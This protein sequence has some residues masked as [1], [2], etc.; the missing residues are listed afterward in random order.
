MKLPLKVFRRYSQQ[1]LLYFMKNKRNEIY[2]KYSRHIFGMFHMA[3]KKE[4]INY[5]EHALQGH[6]TDYKFGLFTYEFHL[7]II[8][9]ELITRAC[10]EVYS[11]LYK[12]G[13]ARMFNC[14]SVYH[15][16]LL[17]QVSICSNL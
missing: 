6:F 1:E 9:S 15:I 13:T 11:C 2:E 10:Q 3:T 8:I 14:K 17:K 16:P 7:H 4:K 12:D 5:I